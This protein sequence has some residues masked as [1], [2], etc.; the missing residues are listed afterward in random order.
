MVLA[1]S[2]KN[3]RLRQ[4]MPNQLRE[5]CMQA[6]MHAALNHPNQLSLCYLQPN[7]EA[8]CQTAA[9]SWHR[10]HGHWSTQQD[11]LPGAYITT[12]KARQHES[13]MNSP[14]GSR[15]SS[16]SPKK[17]ENHRSINGDR[18]SGWTWCRNASEGSHENDSSLSVQFEVSDHHQHRELHHRQICH[19][20]L[21]ARA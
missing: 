17:M 12:E 9:G 19:Q 13:S 2:G 4:P 3:M 20:A 6:V 10:T 5:A 11:H 8:P 7:T 18:V 1:L 15:L 14:S 21:K 16:H